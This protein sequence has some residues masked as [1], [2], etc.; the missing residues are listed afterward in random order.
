MTQDLLRRIYNGLDAREGRKVPAEVTWDDIE[1]DYR[2]RIIDEFGKPKGSGTTTHKT[3]LPPGFL[4]KKKSLWE[5]FLDWI[6]GPEG[7][8]GP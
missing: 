1:R 3:P 4:N 7:L 8:E 5:R 2:S 6:R